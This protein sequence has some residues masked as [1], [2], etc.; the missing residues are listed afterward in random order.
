MFVTIIM[1]DTIRKVVAD[2]LNN[3]K[4]FKTL[5]VIEGGRRILLLDPDVPSL[6]IS[7][8]YFWDRTNT[9]LLLFGEDPLAEVDWLLV[10][11]HLVV[12][13]IHPLI[14]SICV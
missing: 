9:Y 2:I 5:L 6:K 1:W 10:L 13:F 14:E 8:A 7:I 3:K 4:W 12:F 11:V